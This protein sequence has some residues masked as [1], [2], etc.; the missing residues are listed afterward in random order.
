MEWVVM[1]ISVF[2]IAVL[3]LLTSMQL[4]F[5]I[6]NK[7]KNQ[8]NTVFI[9]LT[10]DLAQYF[11]ASACVLYYLTGKL[12]TPIF[13][14]E[15]LFQVIPTYAVVLSF[16]PPI[17]S[18]HVYFLISV[19]YILMFIVG[20]FQYTFFLDFYPSLISFNMQCC[21][22]VSLYLNSFTIYTIF[23]QQ[24][25]KHS[26]FLFVQQVGTIIQFLV[27]I[28]ICPS[29]K[30]QGVDLVFTLGNMARNIGHIISIFFYTVQERKMARQQR[31]EC[32]DMN[33]EHKNE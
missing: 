15:Q 9:I 24:I 14:I 26:V 32:L 7:Q 16:L 2:L 33:L 22:A 6:F 10:Y 5:M 1:L 20:L 8:L 23:K 4:I 3:L 28:F 11:E 30:S 13:V 19:P 29:V 17:Y 18:R 21:S 25:E 27:F 12:H 31:I